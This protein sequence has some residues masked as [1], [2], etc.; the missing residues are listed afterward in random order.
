MPIRPTSTIG[1]SEK[2]FAI[3]DGPV[4]N[5]RSI[6]SFL[7]WQA[8]RDQLEF[9]R[10][11]SVFCAERVD[12]LFSLFDEIAVETVVSYDLI[13]NRKSARELRLVIP[14]TVLARADRVVA[15]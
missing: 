7:I 13:V 1:W 11:Q 9:H 14:R 2:V 4:T 5:C 12:E 8:Y 3:G 10:C 6:M 15:E